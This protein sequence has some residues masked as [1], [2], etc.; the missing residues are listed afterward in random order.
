MPQASSSEN[1]HCHSTSHEKVSGKLEEYENKLCG[2]EYTVVD[3]KELTATLQE[4]GAC[5]VCRHNLTLQKQVISGLVCKIKMSCPSCSNKVEMINSK[6]IVVSEEG[7]GDKNI[8]DLNVRLFL[9]LRSIGKSKTAANVFCGIMNLPPPPGRYTEYEICLG[10]VTEKVC[11]ESM[12][13]AIEEAVEKRQIRDLCVA[14]DG[15]WQ[16]RG[17]T[18]LN[19]IV[20][21]T[22][23]DTG[24]VLDVSMLSKHCICPEK[25]G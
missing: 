3:L 5:R 15:S 21:L 10:S 14:V 6:S 13:S 16:R 4:V 25:N 9:G 24:K 22:S 19:G 8:Y 7:K 12:S 1:L 17:H 23:D 11:K 20:S 18:S 2:F